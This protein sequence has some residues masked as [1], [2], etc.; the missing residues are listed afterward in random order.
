MK[1]RIRDLWAGYTPGHDI[2]RGLDLDVESGQA[3]GIIGLNGSGKSTLAR[4]VMNMLPERRGT[5][6]FNG[7]DI[8]R[9]PTHELSRAGIGL[10][11]Q[12]GRVFDE[13]TIRENLKIAAAPNEKP[14]NALDILGLPSYALNQR[15]DRL[16]GGERH[17]LALAL[18]LLRHPQLLI[19]DEPSAGLDP[20]STDQVYAILHALWHRENSS[21]LIIEHNFTR[22]IKTYSTTFLIQVGVIKQRWND[23]N[24]SDIENTLFS[25]IT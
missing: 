9:K 19:L 20:K 22:A 14:E 3:V 2:L 1:L 6:E 23:A 17:R 13:L 5:I 24:V 18:C 12:G 16:S 7:E 21:L 8:T 4:A 10:F 15:T 11:M 25:G